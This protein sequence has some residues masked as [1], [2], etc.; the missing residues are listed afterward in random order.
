MLRMWHAGQRAGYYTV[1]S[2][3]RAGLE[4]ELRERRRGKGI[5]END[6]GLKGLSG[7]CREAVLT[8]SVEY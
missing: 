1:A 2:V 7:I 4:M 3:G 5:K 8:I 6:I